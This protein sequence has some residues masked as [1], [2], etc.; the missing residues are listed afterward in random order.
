VD[1]NDLFKLGY[2]ENDFISLI[3]RVNTSDDT[4]QA[5]DT[6][7]VTT[8]VKIAEDTHITEKD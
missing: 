7:H 2:R 8:T 4:I 1:V 5:T 3:E 6:K